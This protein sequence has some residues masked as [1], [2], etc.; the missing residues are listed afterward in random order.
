ML[1][2][3]TIGK[4]YM[5]T[6]ET[7]ITTFRVV[8]VNQETGTIYLV[9][10]CPH[11]EAVETLTH[12]ESPSV[13]WCAKEKCWLVSVES[14]AWKAMQGP[15][16]EDPLTEL[17]RFTEALGGYEYERILFND[18]IKEYNR[19]SDDLAKKSTPKP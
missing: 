5:Y 6:S 14:N 15:L 8:N 3:P 12:K 10:E 11:E 16:E 4:A 7:G 1:Q 9:A 13:V 17:T 19:M 2:L 18:L